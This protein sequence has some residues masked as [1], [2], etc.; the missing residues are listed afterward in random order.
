M[1]QWT[2]EERAFAVKAYYQNGESL[3]R[4]RRVFRAHFNV[5]RNQPVPSDHAIK[6]WVANFEVSGSTSKKR[7]GSQ[8][9]VRTPENIGRV[10]EA[11][12]RSP[13]R[14]AVRHATTLG[15]TPRSVRRIL[16]NDLHYHPYKI[17]I[18]QALNTRDYGARVRFCQEML[19]LIG[20][21]EDLVNNMW[22][23]DEAHFH[24]S[25]F[26][27]KQNFR[28]WSQ[29]NPRALHEKPLHSPK[30]T[31]W[32]AISASGIIGPYFFEN[33]TGN[34][35]TVNADRYVEMLQNFFTP[36]LARFHVNEN[37]LF[38][39]DGATSHTARMSMNAV[40]ALF[41][42]RVVSRNGDIPCPTPR[43]PD[44]TPCDYFLWGYLKTKVFE[45]KPRTIADLKQRIQ[46]EVAAIPVEMLREIMN[47]FT[48]RIEE[49]LRRNGSHLEGVIFKT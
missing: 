22:M 39:Q 6:T 28:Y 24:V 23:S 48:S 5:P 46:D 16:H 8:K 3:V 19:D 44:L 7:G 18:V 11:F 30:V 41:P 25:G 47:S 35:V 45:T 1:Q 21:D 29:A 14:S 12:D 27:N 36:Q 34:A 9:T 15:I 40:K 2:G 4:A 38:Q 37:T 20:E 43:S 31:V 33:E 17:Q 26:V 42:K 10:R 13:R 49:C 32:C